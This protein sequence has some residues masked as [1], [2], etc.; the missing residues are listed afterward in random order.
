MSKQN[1]AD[2]AECPAD[3][4]SQMDSD[5]PIPNH[6]SVNSNVLTPETQSQG[7]NQS[8]SG[9]SVQNTNFSPQCS[10]AVCVDAPGNQYYPPQHFNP[11]QQN[12]VV[13]ASTP[14]R[15]YPPPQECQPPQGIPPQTLP[16]QT[17]AH[18][19]KTHFSEEE[20]D[21][22]PAEDYVPTLKMPSAEELAEA[23]R[24]EM[25]D[26]RKKELMTTKKF[27]Q[28]Q[29][30]YT[31]DPTKYC[32]GACETNCH[33]A[34]W[35]LNVF[36]WCGITLL[37]LGI[38]VFGQPFIVG[39][40]FA[41][42][43]FYVAN[44]VES[45]CG[46]HFKYL[47]HLDKKHTFIQTIKDLQNTP[48]R[49]W[50]TCECY[51]YETR[52]RYITETYTDSNG[53]TQVRQRRET[54]EEKVVTATGCADFRYKYFTDD[55]GA[56]NDAVHLFDAIRVDFSKTYTFGDDLTEK[57][58]H[59]QREKFLDAY[60]YLDVHFDNADHWDLPGF[61]EHKMCLT[62][63]KKR[64]CCMNACVYVLFILLTVPMFHRLWLDSVSLNAKFHINKIVF[65]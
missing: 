5:S 12:Q 33:A 24:Q 31:H 48:P 15:L 20:L 45:C 52:V 39:G 14:N 46:R 35:I 11:L 16:G 43:L 58:Y 49:I 53:N 10:Y 37:L 41:L 4:P 38:F 18:T 34:S 7:P 8:P 23:E 30:G 63:L 40:C 62:D 26:I 47:I 44:I 61:K 56:L 9:S 29:E 36:A 2:Q 65:S 17:E 54:Y 60:R 27:I 50:W 57:R 19:N 51:H 3:P 1:S 21:M 22:M 42:I 28:I 25:T 55:S 64:P 6:S 13:P 32:C 59:R